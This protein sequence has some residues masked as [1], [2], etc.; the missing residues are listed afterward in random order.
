MYRDNKHTEVQLIKSCEWRATSVNDVKIEGP[1]PVDRS[2]F[3]M[4]ELSV[5]SNFKVR[6]EIPLSIPKTI[7]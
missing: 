4:L 5:N 3:K 7:I 6:F 1:D 2:T